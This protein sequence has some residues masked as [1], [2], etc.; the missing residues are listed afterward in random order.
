MPSAPPRSI[1]AECNI[2]YRPVRICVISKTKSTSTKQLGSFS[3]GQK[4]SCK[5]EICCRIYECP[6]SA[7]V[8]VQ[9]SQNFIGYPFI[10]IRLIACSQG[11]PSRTVLCTACVCS[12]VLSF[13]LASF[14]LFS[15]RTKQNFRPRNCT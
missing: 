1:K 5:Q 2:C 3:S 15:G 6:S 11:V 10:L 4:I 12:D 7:S 13:R 9:F 8:V 14:F